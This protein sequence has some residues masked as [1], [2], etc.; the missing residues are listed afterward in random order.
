MADYFILRTPDDLGPFA[1]RLLGRH[2][3]ILALT[4]PLGAGKTTLTQALAQ[5]LGVTASVTS[6]TF[7]LQ[8]VYP[9]HH[10]HYDTLVHVDCYRLKN[11]V[12]ELPALDLAHWCQQPRVLVVVEWADRIKNFLEKYEAVWVTMSILPGGDRRVVLS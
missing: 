7:S 4:G 10:P 6:P 12:T 8:Q 2:P 5:A 3:R 11:P 9:A 1:Q